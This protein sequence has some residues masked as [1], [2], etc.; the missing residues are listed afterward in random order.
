[1]VRRAKKGER[2][3]WNKINLTL[4]PEVEAA[5]RLHEAMEQISMSEI[6]EQVLRQAL[7][8][9]IQALPCI[10]ASIGRTES[11]QRDLSVQAGRVPAAMPQGHLDTFIS[12]GT[13]DAR[14]TKQEEAEDPELVELERSIFN[15]FAE[16]LHQVA[17]SE[18]F[19]NALAEETSLSPRRPLPKKELNKT[20]H[21]VDQW[22]SRQR[23]PDAF[24]MFIEGYLEEISY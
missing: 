15:Q 16:Q 3:G 10:R 20:R 12:R 2:A 11:P 9:T 8:A 6:V 24:R 1:M 5:L 18:D 4:S 13:T 19:I 14:D 17:R 22:F 7:S 21:E 23:I